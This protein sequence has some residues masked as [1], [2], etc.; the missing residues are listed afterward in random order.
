MIAAPCRRAAG[1]P[2]YDRLRR[3]VNAGGC[4][5]A[6][7]WGRAKTAHVD[8]AMPDSPAAFA[9]GKKDDQ[10]PRRPEGRLCAAFD[11]VV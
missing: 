7:A 2:C 8:N 1:R 11:K 5:A 4:R 6:R 9:R 10:S 3:S